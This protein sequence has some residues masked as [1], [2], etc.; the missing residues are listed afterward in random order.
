MVPYKILIYFKN[1]S[2]LFNTKQDNIVEEVFFNGIEYRC[3]QPG[4]LDPF[5]L[6]AYVSLL[7][8]EME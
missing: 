3:K 6:H 8:S 7:I 4:D 5:G 1:H 2:I